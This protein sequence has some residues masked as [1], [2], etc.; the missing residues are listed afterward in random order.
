MRPAKINDLDKVF[1]LTEKASI[2]I[3]TLPRNKEVM[4]KRIELSI[5]SFQKKVTEPENEI[6]FFVLVD[7]D[8]QAILGCSAIQ[9]SVGNTS[10]FY[11]Y[12]VS[13]LVNF[14]KEMEFKFSTNI[15]SLVNDYQGVAE[16]ISLYLQDKVRKLGFGKLLSFSRLLFIANQPHRFSDTIIAEL[17]GVSDDQ[18]YSPF[19][20]DVGQHF[21]NIDFTRADYLTGI[22]YKQFIADLM[23]RFPI[24]VCLLPQAAQDV[25]GVEHKHSKGAR[26]LLEKQGFFYDNYVDIFD[27]GPTLQA[28]KNQIKMI[29]ESTV[30]KI[31]KILK[32]LDNDQQCMIATT[33]EEFKACM[34]TVLIA[35]DKR[36]NISENVA[37]A[38]EV[39]VG[40]EI[41]YYA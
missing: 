16:L 28:Q 22:G 14:S 29:N 39:N 40:D 7:L 17:R 38:L 5:E 13:K 9:A 1:A 15:L 4:K 36:V 10:P 31:G 12:K 6:Y 8:N 26:T 33:N 34:G 2:G 23:P 24:Y 41:R 27:A 18:G 11:S 21:F 30:N 35:E 3:T 37:R 19:W 20:A 32:N 25:I